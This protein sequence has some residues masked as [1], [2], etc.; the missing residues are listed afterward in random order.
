MSGWLALARLP[1]RQRVCATPMPW[2]PGPVTSRQG[3][4][5]VVA[6][7][8]S[9]RAGTV[10]MSFALPSSTPSTQL[11][12]RERNPCSRAHSASAGR[13]VE[14][15]SKCPVSS[16][17]ALRPGPWGRPCSQLVRPPNTNSSG[18][19]AQL[20]RPARVKASV[21]T[22]PVSRAAC[23]FSSCR[24]CGLRQ[25]PGSRL[26]IAAIPKARRPWA[27]A[28]AVPEGFAPAEEKGQTE[29]RGSMPAAAGG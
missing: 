28:D 24:P 20:C 6:P 25:P 29:P 7:S 12:A 3:V 8:T 9:R 26:S 1:T 5:P 14:T 18:R 13:A 19:L 11:S 16:P 10:P 27:S 23:G 2:L 22:D 17:S 4:A 21:S 15:M